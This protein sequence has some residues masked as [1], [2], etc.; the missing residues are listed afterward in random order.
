MWTSFPFPCLFWVCSL[1]TYTQTKELFCCQK[2]PIIKLL[3]LPLFQRAALKIWSCS[4]CL[5]ALQRKRHISS[6]YFNL[7]YGCPSKPPSC[8][9]CCQ[10]RGP[11]KC[12]CPKMHLNTWASCRALSQRDSHAAEVLTPL[13]SCLSTGAHKPACTNFSPVPSIPMTFYLFISRGGEHR[14]TCGHHGNGGICWLYSFPWRMLK[15]IG[16]QRD[17]WAKV[18]WLE[19]LELVEI[20]L[21]F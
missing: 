18:S 17:T 7:L 1:T 20:T 5:P 11:R 16:K 12:S 13:L 8:S 14:A 21:K 10:S 2:K 15:T 9:L 3:H 6:K 19:G 4:P